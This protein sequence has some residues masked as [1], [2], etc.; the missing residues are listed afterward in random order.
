MSYTASMSQYVSNILSEG[1]QIVHE[2]VGGNITMR[3]VNATGETLL[4]RVFA[5]TAYLLEAGLAQVESEN[6]MTGETAY[7]RVIVAV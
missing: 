7:R 5:Q 3:L 2:N 6:F 4:D 1:G